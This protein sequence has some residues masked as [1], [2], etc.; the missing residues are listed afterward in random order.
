MPSIASKT[1]FQ[2]ET[3]CCRSVGS[4][5]ANDRAG[6]S[7]RYHRT[8]AMEPMLE[9]GLSMRSHPFTH[10]NTA[11]SR[12]ERQKTTQPNLRTGPVW[13]LSP[14]YLPLNVFHHRFILE[15]GGGE[16]P[17]SRG[18][19]K[20]TFRIPAELLA[21]VD[22]II[23]RSADTRRDGQWTTSSFIVRAIE[24][25]VSKMARSAGTASPVPTVYGRDSST[26]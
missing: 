20:V 17:M 16:S 1:S 23:L 18:S 12:L 5:N 24:E 25:K 4:V 13:P 19:P 21:L 8:Q 9:R 10:G 22:Q 26:Y 11:W 3:N 15:H 14:I 2:T 6:L 7:L